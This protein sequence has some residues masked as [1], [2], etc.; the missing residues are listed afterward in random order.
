MDP[1]AI[2]KVNY[3]ILKMQYTWFGNINGSLPLNLRL[4]WATPPNASASKAKIKWSRFVRA[5]LLSPFMKA[6]STVS[7]QRHIQPIL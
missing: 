4:F 6:T 1:V 3:P 7:A 2:K 5:P